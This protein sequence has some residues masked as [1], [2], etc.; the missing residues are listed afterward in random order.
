M[1][2]IEVKSAVPGAL[3]IYYVGI[4]DQVKKGDKI[5]KIKILSEPSQ[6]E[7]AKTNMKRQ[8][9]FLKKTNS[10]MNVKKDFLKKAL[11]LPVNLKRQVKLSMSA[12]NNTSI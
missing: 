1:K 4:G 3:E 5:A 7:S 8:Q 10:I 12:A 9:L 6:I 2:E 11:S